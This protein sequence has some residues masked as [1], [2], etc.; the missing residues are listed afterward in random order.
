L[1]Q[2]TVMRQFN[3]SRGETSVGEAVSLSAE[4]R[5]ASE[6]LV[7]VHP[8]VLRDAEHTLG[9]LFQRIYHAT[10]L[11]RE[12]LGPQADRLSAAVE[13]LEAV[14]QL[15]FDYV[16]PVDLELRAIPLSRI[17]E[18]LGSAISARTKGKVL[19]G[20]C[21][22]APVLA[23]SRHL[24]RCFQLLGRACESDWA[25][26]DQVAVTVRHDAAAEQAE[27]LITSTRAPAGNGS[28]ADSLLWAVAARLIDL[29]GGALDHTPSET[30]NVWLIALPTAKDED[31]GI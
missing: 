20:E 4:R 27:L 19:L 23:D 31:A 21:P 30:M 18:S 14:V 26:A 10:R 13:D 3:V 11:H 29:H 5:V 6:H 25:Q 16:S 22:V 1:L 28:R 24:R 2:T 17:V 15:I 12:G 7:S 9:N 8:D